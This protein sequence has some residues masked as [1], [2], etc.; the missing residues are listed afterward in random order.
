MFFSLQRP[1]FYNLKA[2]KFQV[3]KKLKCNHYI[4][5]VRCFH[6]ETVCVFT[7]A[8]ISTTRTL[9]AFNLDSSQASVAPGHDAEVKD[10]LLLVGLMGL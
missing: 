2:R 1:I 4:S 6:C 7:F 3:L 5:F 9:S 8:F 10:D